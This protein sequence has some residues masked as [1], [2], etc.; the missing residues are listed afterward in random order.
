MA[1]LRE[2]AGDAYKVS[3]GIGAGRTPEFAG[4]VFRDPQAIRM[5]VTDGAG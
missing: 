1:I 5:L 3:T 2:P 4:P